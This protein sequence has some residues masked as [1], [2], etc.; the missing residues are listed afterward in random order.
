MNIWRAHYQDNTGKCNLCNI[1]VTIDDFCIFEDTIVCLGCCNPIKTSKIRDRYIN[2]LRLYCLY[3]IKS[4]LDVDNIEVDFALRIDKFRVDYI[5]KVLNIANLGDYHPDFL[6]NRAEL[7]FF[8]K[9]IDLKK[10][11]L[12]K[13]L[14]AGKIFLESF[15][16]SMLYSPYICNREFEL[17]LTIDKLD[18]IFKNI[19]IKFN[20]ND[21]NRV[22]YILKKVFKH[23][24]L[25]KISFWNLINNKYQINNPDIFNL[26]HNH[27]DDEHVMLDEYYNK[28]NSIVNFLKNLHN[29]PSNYIIPE[30][31]MTN[32]LDEY[33]INIMNQCL[34]N[35]LSIITGKPGTGKCFKINTPVLMYDGS[36]KKIQN[37]IGG[38]KI[39]G[40]DSTSRNVMDI[41][42]GRDVMYKIIT[43][44]GDNFIVNQ[45]HVLCLYFKNTYINISVNNFL[46]LSLQQQQQFKIYK[47]AIEFGYKPTKI[48]P[49]QFGYNYDYTKIPHEYKC[50]NRY[51]RLQL[52]AG[53]IDANNEFNNESND[54]YRII[55]PV[56]QILNKYEDDLIYLI[57]SLGYHITIKYNQIYIRGLR[58]FDIPTLKK[59]KQT[60]KNNLLIYDFNI[61]KLVEDDYYGVTIDG[62]HKFILGNFI[63][64]HNSQIIGELITYMPHAIILA[65]TG[66]AVETIQNRFPDFKSNTFTLHNFYYR[67]MVITKNDNQYLKDNKINDFYHSV[68][69][70]IIID[71]FSMVDIFIFS[72]LISKMIPYI[73]NLKMIIVGD[74]NQLPSIQLGQILKDLIDS[75]Y[76]KV[77]KLT[78]NYRSQNGI[79]TILDHLIKN[80]RIGI[81]TGAVEIIEYTGPQSILKSSNIYEYFSDINKVILCPTNIA[82]DEINYYIQDHNPNDVICGY[83]SN[84]KF[85]KN[86]K[87]IFLKNDNE[88]NLYN[89]TILYIDEI[90]FQKDD[91]EFKFATEKSFICNKDDI[92]KYLKLAYASTIH[93][94]Q[95]KQYDVVFLLLNKYPRIMWDIKLIY[96]A[97]SRAKN[98]CYISGDSVEIQKSCIVDKHKITSMPL[99]LKE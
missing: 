31:Q 53:I 75:N 67:T 32:I 20:P 61:H 66:C 42:K 72:K 1:P 6:N 73:N 8:L 92:N 62:N 23:Q 86:D 34:I 68:N 48:S 7:E 22:K 96:T 97:I 56:F 77:Y 82:V 71:E 63:V 74:P 29:K 99:L 15:I 85:K 90:I 30:R 27:S 43:N 28:E 18:S 5:S 93:K 84:L 58:L 41:I 19:S 91:V 14:T 12:F 78:K 39:M 52:L 25:D 33:Q 95:G 35:N 26:I 3:K 89:G 11:S 4:K 16:T 57:S 2:E 51:N 50:N 45:S 36:I 69:K 65:P 79:V 21:H 94:S 47:V 24:Y 60:F 98:I 17:K 59:C 9:F 70:C 64:T 10:N 80:K 88:Y 46:E 37:I 13:K 55:C 87:V 54:Y 38:D 76:F 44:I 81:I 40:D 83:S 49:Y